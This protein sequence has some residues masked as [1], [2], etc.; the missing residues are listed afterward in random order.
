[1]PHKSAS[2]RLN[3]DRA[4]REISSSTAR[5]V[6]TSEWL[7]RSSQRGLFSWLKGGKG[8]QT[9][10]QR[11][12]LAIFSYFSSSLRRRKRRANEHPA[13]APEWPAKP[14]VVQRTLR[15]EVL[16]HLSWR[17][18]CD[19]LH[20]SFR[21]WRSRRRTIS[22]GSRLPRVSKK[23]DPISTRRTGTAESTVLTSLALIVIVLCRV[24]VAVADTPRR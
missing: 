1:L 6:A 20:D 15:S 24:V 2:M 10:S 9:S 8:Y 16:P 7:Q 11:H 4:I 21:L 5:F 22:H 3:Q 19:H 18:C 14:Q 23:P 17:P 12:S 13:A